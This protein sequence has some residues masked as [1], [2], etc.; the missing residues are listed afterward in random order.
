[1]TQS[2]SP[3]RPWAAAL[4][5][6][7][8]G[9]GFSVPAQAENKIEVTGAFTRAAPAGGVGGMFL[10]I[11]NNGPA[12]RL[13]GVASPEAA[14]VEL[15]ESTHRDGVARMRPV[16]GLDIPAGGTVRLAPGGYHIMLM[17]L[18]HGLTAGGQ[19]AATLTFEKAG[20]VDVTASVVKAGAG[21]PGGHG[22]HGMGQMPG[23]APAK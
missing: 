6:A 19:A 9:L 20:N 11:T 14:K 21:A 8:L 12:D 5:I 13:I 23:M 18:K 7:A 1:M 3:V 22:S 4:L 15:H 16:D 17:G 10:D 2:V